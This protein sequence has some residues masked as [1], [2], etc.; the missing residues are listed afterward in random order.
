M[1]TL[2]THTHHLNNLIKYY[3][4]T[5]TSIMNLYFYNYFFT[6]NWQESRTVVYRLFALSVFYSA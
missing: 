4:I 2:I 3:Y 5:H 1:H 6:T